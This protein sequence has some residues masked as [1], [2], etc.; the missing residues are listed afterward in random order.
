MQRHSKACMY[1]RLQPV[2]RSTTVYWN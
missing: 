1:G 2:V